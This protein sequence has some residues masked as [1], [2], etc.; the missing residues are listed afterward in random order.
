MPG[1]SK[2]MPPNPALR[3]AVTVGPADRFLPSGDLL[4]KTNGAVPIFPAAPSTII[5]VAVTPIVT[6]PIIS[7]TPIITPP[8]VN[9]RAHAKA[10][11]AGHHKAPAKGKH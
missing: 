4:V 11:N 8:I 1:S 5:G 3:D 7:P 9:F 2:L 6:P 10:L